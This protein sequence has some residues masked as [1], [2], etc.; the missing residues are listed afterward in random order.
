MLISQ[1]W[2]TSL[3]RANNEGW[4]ASEQELDSGFVRV[5]FETEGFQALPE[6]T[7]PLV[8]GKVEV[9]EELTQ[10]KKPIRYCQVNVARQ[11]EPASCRASSAVPA[12][13]V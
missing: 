7:G 4:K 1:N 2:V 12:T 13:S 3:V 9:V 11:T 10:F 6:T 5:G 8:I